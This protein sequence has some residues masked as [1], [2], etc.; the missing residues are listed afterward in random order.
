[1]TGR[2]RNDNGR[3]A[4][5]MQTSQPNITVTGV[6]AVEYALR[7]GVP[8]WVRNPQLGWVRNSNPNAAKRLMEI[9]PT[10]PAIAYYGVADDD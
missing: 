10:S 2:I 9:N 1:M 3:K 5:I 6:R 8:L 7:T 4:T